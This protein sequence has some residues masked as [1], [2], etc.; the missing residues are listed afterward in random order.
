[1]LT[2]PE[3]C[4]IDLFSTSE[5]DT[6][7]DLSESEP[8]NSDSRLKALL[9]EAQVLSRKRHYSTACFETKRQKFDPDTNMRKSQ[10]SRKLHN[11][12]ALKLNWE[13][14]KSVHFNPKVSLTPIEENTVKQGR[15][16][17][18]S[19]LGETLDNSDSEEKFVGRLGQFKL[20]IA[21]DETCGD[22]EFVDSPDSGFSSETS[23]SACTPEAE[24][25]R[26]LSTSR[27][28]KKNLESR[29]KEETRLNLDGE[30]VM[31]KE[32]LE[33]QRKKMRGAMKQIFL[34]RMMRHHFF[35]SEEKEIR[36]RYRCLWEGCPNPLES[37]SSAELHSHLERYHVKK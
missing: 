9:T 3:D 1:M 17:I 24:L 21:E 35:P 30:S 36:E 26:N 29:V 11:Q 25:V 18:T 20:S 23:C 31:R 7:S 5:S 28:Q 4:S 13:L 34:H 14:T 37:T 16:Y 12:H 19:T 6:K 27:F 10:S 2:K 32:R 33:K 15:R 8:I 22:I